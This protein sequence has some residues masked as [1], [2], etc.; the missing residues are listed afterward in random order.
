MSEKFCVA[1]SAISRLTHVGVGVDLRPHRME[2]RS[3]RRGAIVRLLF[4]PRDRQLPTTR[5]MRAR[6]FESPIDEAI[7]TVTATSGFGQILLQKPFWDDERK[8]LEPLM[9]LTRGD[10]RGHIVSSKID[11]G[12]P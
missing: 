9:R 7:G 6:P 1:N 4:R 10:V 11:Q 2:W 8:F 5:R 12:P 3:G